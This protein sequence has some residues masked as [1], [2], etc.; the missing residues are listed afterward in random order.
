MQEGEMSGRCNVKI[1]KGKR[2]GE[3]CNKTACK[4][5][6][7][8][9]L[10]HYRQFRQ[11]EE[12]IQDF[13]RSIE[14]QTPPVQQLPPVRRE[15]INSMIVEEKEPETETE[16]SGDDSDEEVMD[17]VYAT[18]VEKRFGDPSLINLLK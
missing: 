14:R 9:C 7:N 8:K 6:T 17:K 2:Q 18:W 15:R 16:D 1:T 4:E 13:M 10:T 5:C 11:C 12:S 3:L